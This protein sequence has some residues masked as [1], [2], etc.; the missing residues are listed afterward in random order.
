MSVQIDNFPSRLAFIGTRFNVGHDYGCFLCMLYFEP[1]DFLV[2]IY[3]VNN[4]LLTA[5]FFSSYISCI[6][7]W[8]M[9]WSLWSKHK[10]IRIHYHIHM[11]Y[12]TFKSVRI[13]IRNWR[14]LFEKIWN[15]DGKIRKK[16]LWSW[17][18]RGLNFPVKNIRT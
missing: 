4:F 6:I 5:E 1:E 14:L 7:I 10:Y 3:N 9:I 11:N 2:F 15:Y 16:G 8:A 17:S 13:Y 18:G 12:S